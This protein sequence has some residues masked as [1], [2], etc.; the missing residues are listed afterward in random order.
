MAIATGEKKYIS[1]TGSGANLIGVQEPNPPPGWLSIM[2]QVGNVPAVRC[3]VTDLDIVDPTL[4]ANPSAQSLK[5]SV[6][7]PDWQMGSDFVVEGD[8][9]NTN[10]YDMTAP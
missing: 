5:I 6:E 4:P 2:K 10:D 7:S 8:Y 9:V 3:R 1:W